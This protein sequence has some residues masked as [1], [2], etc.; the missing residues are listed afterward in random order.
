MPDVPEAAVTAALDA[1]RR[2]FHGMPYLAAFTTEAMLRDV[3]EA[4]LP[5]LERDIRDRI[6]AS[7]RRAAEGRREYAAPFYGDIEDHVAIRAQLEQAA[8]A[9]E[10]SAAII[11]D[12]K[13]ILGVIPSWRWTEDELKGIRP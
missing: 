7:L 1:H 2:A 3:L 9:Y 5:H 4:A 8:R 11:E 6:A 12:P 10:S 13:N